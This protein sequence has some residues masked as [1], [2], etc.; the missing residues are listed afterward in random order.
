M[1]T[2]DEKL[3]RNAH[4]QHG[5]ITVAQAEKAGGNRRMLQSR[6]RRGVLVQ[7]EVDVFRFRASPPTW[8]SALLA[9]VLAAGPGAL[10]SHRAAAALWGLEGFGQATPELSVPRH[11]RYR[12][13]GVRSHESSDLHLAGRRVRDGIPVTDPARTLLDVARFVGPRR[14]HRAIESARRQDLTSWSELVAVLTKHARQGRRG[15]RLL[16]S[17][18][19]ANMHRDEVTDSD[20]E[21]LV[22]VLLL[23]HGLPE[24]ELHHRLLGAD[25]QPLAEIDLAYP[26]LRIAIELDGSVHQTDEVFQR[27]RPRQNRIALAGWT[28]LRFTWTTFVND[29]ASIVAEVR[30]AIALRTAAA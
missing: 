22:I 26:D 3:A 6:A 13:R 14:L 4:N 24:P 25:G 18:I 29:P 15:V 10:A 28:I 23:E 5:L 7:E 12:R 1:T 19:A 11:R 20:F 17:V 21:L 16:R 8:H 30:A 9:R 27:D 2:F